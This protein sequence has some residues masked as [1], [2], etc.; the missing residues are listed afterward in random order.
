MTTLSSLPPEVLTRIFLKLPAKDCVN[1][2]KTCR[3]TND[4]SKI[5]FIWENKIQTDFGIDVKKEEQSGPSTRAFYWQVLQKYGKLLGLW[6]A[7]TYGHRGGLFQVGYFEIFYINKMKT[8]SKFE[9]S[10]FAFV[11]FEIS[12]LLK[13]EIS[14]FRRVENFKLQKS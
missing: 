2:A 6:Q 10:A 13:L 8:T 9:S 14:S 11:C 7:T 1:L 5:E 12:T 4:I 3:F